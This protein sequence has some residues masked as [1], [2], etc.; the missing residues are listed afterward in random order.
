MDSIELV[1]WLSVGGLVLLAMVVLSYRW[2][3]REYIK[4]SIEG[5]IRYI[6]DML[7]ERQH[8][9]QKMAQ[10]AQSCEYLMKVEGFRSVV[11]LLRHRHVTRAQVRMEEFVQ[12]WHENGLKLYNRK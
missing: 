5:E 6:Y 11:T 3:R 12:E 1:L 2:I 4:Y 7:M 8:N 9:S 10:S